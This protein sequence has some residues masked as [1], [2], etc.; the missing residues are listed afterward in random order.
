MKNT[1]ALLTAF[2]IVTGSG[3]PVVLADANQPAGVTAKSAV[4]IEQSTG[5]V[6]YDKDSHQ[7]LDIGDIAIEL[8]VPPAQRQHRTI[9][10]AQ[11]RVVDPG[12][13]LPDMDVLIKGGLLLFGNRGGADR[14]FGVR[15]GRV[16]LDHH[17]H[18]QF[19]SVR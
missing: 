13:G 14:V 5:Q 4:M 6:L 16:A 7:R 17:P 2:L 8:V 1:L 12:F 3:L 11:Q 18:H 10:M 9:G 19:E 15:Q